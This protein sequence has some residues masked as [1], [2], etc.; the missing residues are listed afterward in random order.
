MDPFGLIEQVWW[1]GIPVALLMRVLV[2]ASPA[3]LPIL[4]TAIGVG[5]SG[6]LVTKGAGVRQ[7]AASELA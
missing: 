6:E 1:P 5:A 3:A 2:G 4:S 7:A